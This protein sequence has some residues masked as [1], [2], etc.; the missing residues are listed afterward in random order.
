[1]KMPPV[2]RQLQLRRN[3]PTWVSSVM[4]P[5]D[6]CRQCDK[7]DILRHR[8]TECGE[9]PPNVELDTRSSAITEHRP[10]TN[11]RGLALTSHTKCK[12]PETTKCRFMDTRQFYYV[13]SATE[14]NAMPPR[15]TRLPATSEMKV[16]QDGQ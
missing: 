9:G 12:I 13:P 3:W 4:T 16:I 5:T 7:T 1:M 11:P 8:L 15:L 14:T 6:T 2:T 10:K